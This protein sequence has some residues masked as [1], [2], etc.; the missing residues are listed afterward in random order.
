MM[1]MN[2]RA[3]ALAAAAVLAI[4]L[5]LSPAVRKVRVTAER[6]AVYVEPN[7][8]SARID[9][10]ERGDLLNLFQQQKVK[11][12]WYYVSYNSPRYGGRI[13]GFI[14]ES[15]VELV[16]EGVPPAK[17]SVPATPKVEAEKKPP[18]VRPQPAP[19]VAAAPPV[20]QPKKA[21]PKPPPTRQIVVQKPAVVEYREVIGM[22]PLAPSRRVTLPRRS[23]SVQDRPWA[24]LQPVV[25]EVKKGPEMPRARPVPPIQAAPKVPAK[26]STVEPKPP[27]EPRAE[28]PRSVTPSPPPP[29][30]IKPA[31]PQKM[32]R[33][34]SPLSVGL[35]YGSS[36]GGAGGCLQLS[37]TS[38]L[39]IHAGFGLYPAAVVY[40]DTDWVK[41]TTLWIAGIRYYPPV[42]SERLSPYI[43]L[44]YGGLR[45]E[46]AQVITGI[47]EFAYIY[48]HEQ[49]T[50]WGPSLLAGLEIRLGRLGL[51][52]GLGVSYSITSWEFLRQRL[53]LAFEAG[54]SLG[55]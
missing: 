54:V 39:A 2:T 17:K 30:P 48:R 22:T 14:Q 10:V 37:L 41:N 29:A 16:A 50:L 34:L 9:L 21:E 33:G 24:I 3:I 8:N 18:E 44:Q 47:F 35:G 40:S 5:P 55:L 15:A 36:Y 4:G 27:A 38:R 28:K 11:D 19:A 20:A 46:A 42:G 1:T 45:V 32:Q 49:K 53:A 23:P 6:A 31:F 12:V 25:P 52:G 51:V 26:K 7:R 13:S 43:D